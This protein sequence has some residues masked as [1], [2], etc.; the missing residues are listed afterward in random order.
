MRVRRELELELEPE[1]E[2]E[3]EREPELAQIIEGPV[4]GVHGP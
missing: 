2:R 3:L 1:R 4:K